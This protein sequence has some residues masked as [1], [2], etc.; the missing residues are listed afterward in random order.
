MGRC[1]DSLICE[2]IVSDLLEDKLSLGVNG[3]Q[4]AGGQYLLP[5]VDASQKEDVSLPGQEVL[6]PLGLGGVSQLDQVLGR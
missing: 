3:I 6:S 4:E 1:L 5:G 2:D